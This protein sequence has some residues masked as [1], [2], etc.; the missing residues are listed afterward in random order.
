MHETRISLTAQ[1]A[2]GLSLAL[3]EL[4]TNATKYVAFSNATGTVVMSW[5]VEE[6]TFVLSG[7]KQA[8]R[9]LPHQN[10][11]ALALGFESIV[12]SYFDGEGRIDFD[13]AGM[14][15]SGRVSG[16]KEDLPENGLFFAK[17]YPPDGIIKALNAIAATI[18]MQ[19]FQQ[20]L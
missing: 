19:P 15:T 8:G 1:Q 12:A 17:P 16:G 20:F 3:H 7:T 9:L 4:A 14:V 2:L 11:A 10:V 13:P 18:K 6:D 5:G